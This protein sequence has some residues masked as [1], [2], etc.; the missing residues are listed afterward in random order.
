MAGIGYATLSVLP[1]AKGFGSALTSSVGSEMDSASK[2][3]GSRLSSGMFNVLKAGAVVTGAAIVATVGGA[4]VSGWGRLTAIENAT[5]KLTGLGNSATTVKSIM[6]NALASVKGTAYGLDE[7]ATVAAG[8]VAAGI[9]PGLELR[10]ILGLTAD[11]ATIAGVSMGEMGAIFNKVAS[12]NKIQGDVIAQLNDAGIPIVQLLG[13]AMG[14]TSAEVTAMASAGKID[15]KTFAKAME[16]GLGGAA[17]KSGET[18]QGA[19]ANMGAALSRFGAGLLTG[20]FPIAKQVF[21]GITVW[22]DDLTV[23]AAPFAAAFSTALTTFITGFQTGEGAGGR[24]RDV[25][26]AIWEKGIVPVANFITGTA[27]PAIQSFAQGFQDGTGIGGGFKDFLVLLYNDAVKPVGDFLTGTAVPAIQNFVQ[28]FKDGKGPG[29]DFRDILKSAYDDGIVPLAN[30]ITGTALPNLKLIEEWITGTG[31]ASLGSMKQWFDDNKDSLAGLAGFITVT[32]LP[33]VLDMS[34]KAVAAWVATASAGVTSAAS[35]LASHY[36]AVGGWTL[37]AGAALSS[38]AETVAIWALIA[39]DS[40]TSAA[41]QVGSHLAAAA[42]WVSDAATSVLAGAIMVGVWI[43][44]GAQSVIGAAKVVG[45]HAVAIAGWIA[46][47]ATATASGITMAAAWVIGLGPIAWII[48]G[49]GLLVAAF[50][51]AYNNV[52]W[53]KDGVDWMWQGIQNSFATAWNAVLA[54]VLRWL[55][56]GFANV[57]TSFGN[58]LVALGQVPGFGWAKDAGDKILGAASQVKGF[59]QSIKDIPPT[60]SVAINVNTSAADANIAAVQ[61]RIN[62]LYGKNV[63][64]NVGMSGALT[65]GHGVTVIASPF[66]AGGTIAPTP[67]GSIVRV[68]EAGRS[69]TIVDTA[70]L[71]AAMAQRNAAPAAIGSGGPIRLHPD[72]MDYIGAVILAGAVRTAQGVISYDNR[73]F[74]NTRETQARRH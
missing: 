18:T 24:F 26:T 22:L 2:S 44:Q 23:K 73:S 72:D 37:S 8:A 15:F 41:T 33:V 38:G 57:M 55:C 10:R 12:A 11:G 60:K 71:R 27:I 40:V 14:K 3:L 49:I 53:F 19:F 36:V 35:Q 13:K 20:V 62:A 48:A 30:F 34:V 51:W 56:D 65:T 9:K 32:F 67:G 68:A 25:L 43:E 42:G 29:G 52:G 58:M 45:A 61:A 28:G 63:T 5:A 70:T 4:L 66:A 1:D 59:S 69:E 6:D 31:G 54:P 39:W 74:D 7:A 17:L 46:D 64:V 47:A 21:G 16:M 50:V